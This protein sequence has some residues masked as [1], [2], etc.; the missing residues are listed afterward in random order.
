MDRSLLLVVLLSALVSCAFVQACS[1]PCVT[2]EFCNTTTSVCE[3]DPNAS[4]SSDFGAQAVCSG[5][6]ATLHLSYCLL[7]SAGMSID[8]LHLNNVDC[9][10]QV[11]GHVVTFNFSAHTCGSTITTNATHILYNNG[12]LVDVNSSNVITREE[13]VQLEMSCALEISSPELNIPLS[14]KISDSNAMLINLTSGAWTYT[15]AIAAFLDSQFTKAINSTTDLLL[16]DN[17]YVNLVATGL[18]QAGIVVVVESCWAT[19]GNNSGNSV[20]WDLIK[21]GCPNK[22]DDSVVIQKNGNSSESSFSFKMFKFTGSAEQLV[23]VHCQ[24][25][26]CVTASNACLPSCGSRRRRRSLKNLDNNVISLSLNRK[27]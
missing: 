24:V 19:P 21:N 22:K 5:P 17:I 25:N 11:E 15:L 3:C 23:F 26:L 14:L 13:A 7:S 4:N 6:S 10:G 2:G 20:R 18:E 1:P 9:K 8:T 27:I 16:N 12:V